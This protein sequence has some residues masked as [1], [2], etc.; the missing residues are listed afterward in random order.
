MLNQ[1]YYDIIE[2]SPNRKNAHACIWMN[3][4]AADMLQ[5]AQFEVYEIGRAWNEIYFEMQS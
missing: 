5:A 4:W 1:P 3:V 2:F